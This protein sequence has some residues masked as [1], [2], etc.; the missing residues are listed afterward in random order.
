MMDSN[1]RDND[2]AFGPWAWIAGFAAGALLIWLMFHLA[3][4][5]S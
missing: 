2:L 4:G 1:D 5:F 3:T